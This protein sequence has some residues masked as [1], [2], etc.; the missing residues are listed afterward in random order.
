[1]PVWSDALTRLWP[2]FS[3][4][5]GAYCAR[6]DQNES[7]PSFPWADVH[8]RERRQTILTSAKNTRSR[9]ACES[10]R[11]RWN[12]LCAGL[13]RFLGSELQPIRMLVASDGSSY[14]S[15][16]QFAPLK[17]HA[18]LLR[19]RLDVVTRFMSVDDAIS[20][21]DDAIA[22]FNV[23]GLKLDFRT[24]ASE[25]ERVVASFRRRLPEGTARLVYFD[26][27]RRLGHHPPGTA[28]PDDVD[29]AVEHLAKL[30]RPRLASRLGRR[31]KRTQPLPLSISQ[32]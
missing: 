11:Y 9:R 21:G 25:A 20:L 24:P 19:R 18:A 30:H 32:I 29:D 28:A 15:E 3:G 7:D 22:A 14:A 4:P 16:Q 31:Q 26:G 6:S 23:V 13:D 8:I 17:R 2:L 12:L 27:E 10:V 5:A 1:V